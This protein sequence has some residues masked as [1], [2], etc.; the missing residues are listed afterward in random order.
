VHF[1]VI[2]LADVCV[3]SNTIILEGRRS[4]K[5]KL[6]S[7]RE[8]RKSSLQAEAAVT[9]LGKPVVWA[10]GQFDRGRGIGKA[11]PFSRALGAEMLSGGCWDGSVARDHILVVFRAWCRFRCSLQ[12]SVAR[13]VFQWWMSFSELGVVFTAD[14]HF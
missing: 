1:F 14:C 3:V 11:R 10:E 4:E 12:F 13:V 7:A 9:A 2:P 6:I 8:A 5:M